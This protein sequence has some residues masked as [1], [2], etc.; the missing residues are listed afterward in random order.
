MLIEFRILAP[1]GRGVRQ[2]E[3]WAVPDNIPLPIWHAWCINLEGEVLELTWEKPGISYIGIPFQ[4]DWLV[5]TFLNYREYGIGGEACANGFP[6][7]TS[8]W[9]HPIQSKGQ[10]IPRS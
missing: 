7:D 10:T 6:E 1:L 4:D 5:E 2:C 8:E 9:V 3:G